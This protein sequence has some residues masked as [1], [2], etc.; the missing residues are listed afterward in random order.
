MYRCP[1]EVTSVEWVEAMTVGVAACMAGFEYACGVDD[2]VDSDIKR[3]IPSVPKSERRAIDP[4][5]STLAKVWEDSGF[6]CGL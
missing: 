1:S 6:V 5:I 4:I 3:Y 2:A